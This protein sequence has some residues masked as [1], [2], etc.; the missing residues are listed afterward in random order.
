MDGQNPAP[1][2]N[3]GKPFFLGIILP[4]S[5]WCEMDFV[6]SQGGHSLQ[7]PHKGAYFNSTKVKCWLGPWALDVSQIEVHMKRSIHPRLTVSEAS[8]LGLFRAQ[9]LQKEKSVVQPCDSLP[10]TCANTPC[11]RTPTLREPMAEGCCS[12]FACLSSCFL[13]FCMPVFK[14]TFGPGKA[15]RTLPASCRT[16]H[17]LPTWFPAKN[18]GM[19]PPWI[20]SCGFE[21]GENP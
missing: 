2:G 3:H 7:S 9:T 20:I 6:H 14:K 16:R 18:E 1:L 19:T 12:S 13:S 21:G 10:G 15:L 11:V 8:F 4:G 17:C 5:L